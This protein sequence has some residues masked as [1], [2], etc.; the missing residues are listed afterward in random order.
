MADRHPEASS[1]F[2]WLLLKNWNSFYRKGLNNTRFSAEPGNLYNKHSYKYSGLANN[3]TVHIA[4][5]ADNGLQVS[6]ARSKKTRNPKSSR[7]SA[8]TKKHHS[9]VSKSVGKVVRQTRPD[10]E[11]AALARLGRVHQGLLASKASKKT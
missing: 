9:K 5:T 2:Q 11:R 7:E 3:N 1:Q 8:T 4:Q 10:L 6:K